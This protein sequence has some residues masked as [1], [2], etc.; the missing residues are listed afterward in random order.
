ML[1]PGSTFAVPM[2]DADILRKMP[3]PLPTTG[4]QTG[5]DAWQELEEVLAE[6]AQLARS[7]LA[8]DEFYDR[9]LSASIRALS[10]VG[11]VVWLRTP[12]G[13]LQP[14]VQSNWQNVGPGDAGARAAHE[15][16]LSEA[17]ESEG[18]VSH[19]DGN[20][21][22]LLA[23]VRLSTDAEQS[24]AQ[25]GAATAAIFEIVPRADASPSAHRGCEQFLTA[26]C[27]VAAEFHLHHDLARLRG[28]EAYREQLVRL[29]SLVHRHIDL[30]PTAYTVANE[31]RRVV[32]CD[33]LSVLALSGRRCRLLATSGASRVERRSGAAR[34]LEQLA[35]LVGPTAEPA[36]YADGQSDALPPIA[37]ALE[38][39]AEDS[40]ARQIAVLPIARPIDGEER[41]TPLEKPSFVLIAEQ[42]DA[43]HGELQRSR[44][45]EVGQV[46]ATALYNARDV[47]QLPLR[48]LLRPLGGLKRQIT[49]HIARSTIIAGLIAAAIAALVLVPADFTVEA[50]GTLEPAVRRDVFASRSGLVER[51]LV[52]DGADVTAG[53]PLVELRDP[54]LELELKRVHGEMETVRRQLDAVRATKTNR[55]IRDA[56]PTEFYRLSASEREFEQQLTNLQRERELLDAER[57]SLI[58]R[59]P[60]AGRIL[61]WDIANRLA[62][63]P[64]ERGDVL[65]TV[66]DLSADWQLELAVADDRIGHVLAAR[67][68]TKESLPVH[69]RLRSQDAP[70]T[71]EV[72]KIALTADPVAPEDAAAKPTVRV[73]TAFDKSQ[74]DDATLRD[75]RPGVSANAEIDC[76]RRPL[77]YVWF[78]DL[79]DTIITWIRF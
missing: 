49:T 72:A 36:Y 57:E 29:G 14:L 15:S 79:W 4:K 42:F 65:V 45:V 33:R 12:S 58:L 43:R 44:L 53:Q 1:R 60:I 68:A 47:D 21:P 37:D 6:L 5:A 25:R 16:R 2:A 69:F 50:P 71:G 73:I 27:E 63:R 3:T 19:I 40:H 38:Q 11:G 10:A 35:D 78:H 32:G 39:H 64:V 7:P 24:P 28:D 74:L 13:A 30:A 34:R 54:K 52:G 9:A 70:L 61:T 59:S 46:C 17:A 56:S 62:A 26:L 67:D 23:P 75:L 18:V 22:L 66:A 8:P 31:G 51:V 76:G 48:W 55:D 20:V 41:R 77:G